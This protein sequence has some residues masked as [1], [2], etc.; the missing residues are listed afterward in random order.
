[1]RLK[2]SHTT[3]YA[4]D[5]PVVSG[6]QQLR[7]TP[8]S[9]R[10]Q[11]V[12]DW[13]MTITGGKQELSYDDHHHNKVNLISFDRDVTE[14]T[15]HCE[16]EVEVSENHGVVGKHV[17]PVPLWL[18]KRHTPRT[19]A[20]PGVKALL[21]SVEGETVLD[22]CH[23]LMAALGEAV[24]YET[25]SSEST[26]TA[27]EAVTEGRGVCQ[28]HTHVF[29][30]CAHEA[31]WPARYVSG[32]LMLDDTVAQDAMH[33]WAEVFVPDLG[34]VGFDAS[35]QMSPDERYVRVAIGLDYSDAAPVNGLRVGGETEALNVAI[36]VAQQ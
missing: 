32:Y 23:K 24:K 10:N 1:M 20:G 13:K 29:I 11:T 15:V 26:W 16:G 28:D 35:N 36:E 2:I 17:G 34:W 7:L 30:A 25:G 4:F 14:V 8:R 22:R 12:T 33:A 18:Y 6:L 21:R 31:G 5:A 9:G 27:E 19:K 3:R